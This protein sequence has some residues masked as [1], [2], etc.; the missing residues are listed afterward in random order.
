MMKVDYYRISIAMSTSSLSAEKVVQ[1]IKDSSLIRTETS[2]AVQKD[3]GNPTKTKT[4]TESTSKLKLSS[5]IGIWS[6]V[7]YNIRVKIKVNVYFSINIYP[8]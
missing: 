7:R 5:G 8:T 6:T 1:K 2:S 4:E 3:P